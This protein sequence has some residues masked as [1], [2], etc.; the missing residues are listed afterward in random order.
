VFEE[1]GCGFAGGF[2]FGGGEGIFVREFEEGGFGAGLG[3]GVDEGGAGAVDALEVVEGAAVGVGLEDVGELLEGEVEDGAAVGR[4]DGG[5]EEG[6]DDAGE[7]GG[8]GG[9]GRWGGGCGIGQWGMGNRQWGGGGDGGVEDTPTL[10][11]PRTRGRVQEGG[12]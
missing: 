12:G 4:C 3:L 2:A 5:V 10:A 7:V 8:G 6:V 9:V 1:C 11:L